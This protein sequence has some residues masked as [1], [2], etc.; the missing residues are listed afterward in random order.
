M[1]L[2][3]NKIKQLTDHYEHKDQRGMSLLISAAKNAGKKALY[4]LGYYN[5]Y[6]RLKAPAENRLLVV[7]Y[8]DFV[9]DAARS[10]DWSFWGRMS[11]AEFRAHLEALTDHFRVIT[12]EDAFEEIDRTGRLQ[13]KSAAIT[14]DDGYLSSY[15]IAY[16]LLR[17]YGV[18][19]TVYLPTD[20]IDRTMTPWWISLATL[21]KKCNHPR[22]CLDAVEGVLGVSLGSNV[23]KEQGEPLNRRALLHELESILRG[24]D[25]ASI[26]RMLSE[27]EKLLPGNLSTATPEEIPIT[28]DQVREMST[29]GIRFGA[30]TTSHA[31]LALVD[32]ATAETEIRDS[33]RRIEEQISAPVTGFAY[34]Y[35]VNYGDYARLKPLLEK[36]GFHYACTA[37][38]G[39][40]SPDT[41]RFRLVRITLPLAQSPAL[42]KRLLILDYLDVPT[43]S[44]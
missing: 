41:D 23:R 25:Q 36:H 14:I 15:T 3:D 1:E 38:T 30:H 44:A 39:V 26:Q 40:N 37:S 5:L 13:E 28:W 34:P 6:G 18:S 16:P 24:R 2:S 17:E 20:W 11:R 27:L 33:K 10:A 42:I 21:I 12:L 43:Q 4:S 35:G 31:N 7:M 32:L 19:A 9:E 22:P 29:G 8:H